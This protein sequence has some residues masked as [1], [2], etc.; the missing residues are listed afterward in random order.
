M[1]SSSEQI[2]QKEFMRQLYRAAQVGVDEVEKLVEAYP[3]YANLAKLTPEG[4]EQAIREEEQRKSLRRVGLMAGGVFLALVVVALLGRFVVMVPGLKA[5]QADLQTAQTQAAVNNAILVQMQQTIDAQAA[6]LT[7]TPTP[8]VPEPT[9]GPTAGP[10]ETM[11]AAQAYLPSRFYLP[12]YETLELKPG[13]PFAP[14]AVWLMDAASAELNPAEGWKD[15][16]D[17]ATKSKFKYIDKVNASAS[18]V[19]DQP[20]NQGGWYALFLTDT[21]Q[22]SADTVQV[23]L[24]ANDQAVSPVLGAGQVVMNSSKSALPQKDSEWLL[25][26]VYPLEQGNLLRIEVRQDGEGQEWTFGVD[27]ALLLKL[28]DSDQALLSGAQSEGRP[29]V[30]LADD[31]DA[32]F[33]ISVGGVFSATKQDWL[34]TPSLAAFNGSLHQPVSEFANDVRVTWS[35]P[36]LLPAGKYEIMA[37]IPAEHATAPVAY[38]LLANGKALAGDS[39]TNGQITQNNEGQWISLGLWQ[40]P[41]DNTSLSVQMLV[42]KGAQGE[43]AADVIVLHKAD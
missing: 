23:N 14:Q 38:S 40:V 30:G 22:Y 10:I 35:F 34:T 8:E 2:D 25:A 3:E 19:L 9:P 4:Y 29:V 36:G 31:S 17:T 27:R 12:P 6:L 13:L 41:E 20:L 33:E 1:K 37:W 5:A 11:P 21:A 16:T 42:A 28:S 26:G 43:A 7:Q 18:W 39:P 15:A 32:K 24:L